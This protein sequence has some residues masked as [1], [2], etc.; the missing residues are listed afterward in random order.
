M[1]RENTRCCCCVVFF[2]PFA[3]LT[4]LVLEWSGYAQRQ[5]DRPELQREADYAERCA[6]I[7]LVLMEVE[8]YERAYNE[9]AELVHQFDQDQAQV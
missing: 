6:T 1:D 8:G 4:R 7:V 3:S 5:G 9:I 2:I